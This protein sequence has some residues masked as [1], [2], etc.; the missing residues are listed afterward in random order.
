MVVYE[1]DLCL[2]ALLTVFLGNLGLQ[3]FDD[4][5]ANTFFFNKIN[6]IFIKNYKLKVN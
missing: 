5:S 4:Y 1:Q 3:G 2:A 6:T